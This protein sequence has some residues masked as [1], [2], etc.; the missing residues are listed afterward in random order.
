MPKVDGSYV[1]TDES[2]LKEAYNEAL[3]EAFN[4]IAED[5]GEELDLSEDSAF[6]SYGLTLSNVLAQYQEEE[7]AEIY[8]SAFLETATG[9]DLDNVVAILGIKRTGASHATGVVE[10]SRDQVSQIDYP[11]PKGTAVQTNE[12]EAV[13]FETTE[14]VTL[15]AGTLN[16]KANIR[17]VSGGPQGNVGSNT[18]TVMPSLPSGV[19]SVTNPT[20]TGTPDR[21]DRD[22]RPYQVGRS[23]ESDEELRE[24]ARVS[25][26][27]G[28]S[29]TYDAVLSALLN[30]EDLPD[31]ISVT[32]YNN[33]SSQ[34]IA[35]GAELPPY[36]HEAVI[37]GGVTQRIAEQL[38]SV[39]ALT[40]TPVGGY[41]G[42]EVTYDVETDSGQMKTIA[43]S[44]PVP[45]DVALTV[46]IVITDEYISDTYIKD[47]VIDYVGG[48]KSNGQDVNGVRSG[49]DVFV[50]V[51]EDR[52]TGV[53][54]TGVKGIASLSTTP[55][56]TTNDDGLEIVDIA[57]NED[58][59]L[60]PENITL[61][62]TQV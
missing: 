32:L 34:T 57:P 48:T 52:I 37:N 41:H 46:D 30:T 2:V 58:A 29:G 25:K 56:I 55:S 26:T 12:I 35:E 27:L 49:S 8:K 61:T 59:Q 11:I 44:R 28:G 5:L 16:Q 20:P 53:E 47:Q 31:V 18:L 7:L 4:T 51:I 62:K 60:V 38:H 3:T 39:I 13:A 40:S 22:G 50:D 36:S 54:D 10:F 15:E 14:A 21:N 6:N 17:A 23:A 45:V 43:F 24:R 33:R 1:P 42:N 9:Q 19:D